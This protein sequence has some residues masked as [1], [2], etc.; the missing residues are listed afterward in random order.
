MLLTARDEA[1][2][3]LGRDQERTLL[4]TILAEVATHGQAL[5]VRGGPGV[6]KSRLLTEI[7]GTAREGACRCSRRRASSLKRIF[8]L[9]GCTSSFARCAGA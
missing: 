6:G 5:V 9:P 8:P 3:L 4:R 1:A 7:A 2:P